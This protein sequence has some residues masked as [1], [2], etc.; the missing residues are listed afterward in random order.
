MLSTY[1]SMANIRSLFA[2][3]FLL[4]MLFHGIEAKSTADRT[5]EQ[6][7]KD[8]RKMNNKGV[9]TQFHYNEDLLVIG[10][11]RLTTLNY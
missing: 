11:Q 9:W 1:C 2:V 4:A 7:G 10:S 3:T 8:A 5:V 6:K